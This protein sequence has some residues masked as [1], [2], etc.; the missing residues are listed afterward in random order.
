MRILLLAFASIL[1]TISVS[2]QRILL[3]PLQE[4]SSD[5]EIRFQFPS[6]LADGK[7]SRLE[8]LTMAFAYHG[9]ILELDL[10]TKPLFSA[11][12]AVLTSEGY[13]GI[14]LDAVSTFVGRVREKE[15]S[16]VTMVVHQ[17]EIQAF[18]AFDGAELEIATQDGELVAYE[19]NQIKEVHQECFETGVQ[20]KPLKIPA[21]YKM[22]TGDCLELYVEVDFQSY[23]D[24]GSSTTA[25]TSWV[26]SIIMP[27]ASSFEKV[28]IP[29]SISE[30]FIWTT[31]D[32][33]TGDDPLTVLNQFTDNRQNNYNG[34]VAQLLTTR[35]IGGGI[36]DGIGGLCGSYPG[37]PAPFMVAGNLETTVAPLPNYSAAVQLVA[38]ELGHIIGSRHTHACVWNGNNTQIDDCGNEYAVANG[39]FPEGDACFDPQNPVSPPAG[40]GT[41]MSRCELTSAGIDLSIGFD[42]QVGVLLN[43][44][45]NATTCQTGVVCSQYPPDNDGCAGA[46]PVPVKNACVPDVYDN[47]LA[48]PSGSSPTFSCGVTGAADDVWFMT[49]VPASGDLTIETT[50]VAG[51]LTDMVVQVYSGSCGS[52]VTLACDDNSGAGNHSQII[53]T[54]RTAGESLFIR[55]IDSGSNQEGTFGLCIYDDNISCHPSY[56]ALISLYNSTNGSSWV[57]RSGWQDGAAGTDCDVCTWYGVVCDAMDRVVQLRL[58]DNNLT[59][60]LPA[61]FSGGQYLEWLD[62]GQNG[63]AGNLP[64]WLD[65]LDSMI[66]LDVGGNSL[67]GGIA[68]LEDMENL[69]IIYLE[70]NNLTGALPAD[71]PIGTLPAIVQLQGNALDGCIP[72]S[73][74]DLCQSQVDLMGNTALSND[75]FASFCFSGF[76][77]DFDADGF[78][79]GNHPNADCLDDDSSSFPG[80]TEVCDGYDNDCNGIA[81]DGV[82]TTAV[83]TGGS[84]G[85]STAGNWSPAVVPA[86]CTDVTISSGTATVDIGSPAF[87]RSLV[88]DGNGLLEMKGELTV[89]GAPAVAVSLAS[90]GAITVEAP[91]RIYDSGMQGMRV[92]GLLTQ[93]DSIIIEAVGL[94]PHLL[95]TPTANVQATSNAVTLLVE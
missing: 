16:L 34:R 36:A 86:A 53:L 32:P 31:Q 93:M 62:L 66:V 22:M 71:L 70:D 14:D 91:L 50:Q 18:I 73:Y 20:G 74:T 19:N 68:V 23:Q 95:V 2:Q 56:D 64:P 78:C 55:I 49:E 89:R 24:L 65:Q 3:Q 27:V 87:A 7:Y 77:G 63:I 52:L 40:A 28:G 29:L 90:G 43:A 59:G 11:N 10:K 4:K 58:D 76:G 80:A 8:W 12:A 60:A 15:H 75:D 46:I 47:L 30:V 88:V 35:P 37:T 67:A 79:S 54:G 38:H 81:D 13:A 69:S 42:E 39:L 26:S 41:I 85:W 6:E 82:S 83:W 94:A 45:Y 1:S 21:S 33:Y 5:S 48:S 61:S 9:E 92:E 84:G 17:G 44:A 51:G 57:D 72:T 25:V